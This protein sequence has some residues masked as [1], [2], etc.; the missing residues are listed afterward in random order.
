MQ[1]KDLKRRKLPD[2]P[3]VY[4][5]VG[6]KSK[7]LYIGKA[8]SLRD[9]VKSYFNKDLLGARGPAIVKMVAEAK[10]VDYTKTDSVLEALILEAH[11][12]KQFKPLYN[13]RS[14][15]DKS[16][17]Y[18][19]VT[20]EE[21]PRI[22]VVRGKDLPSRFPPRTRKYVFGPF[23][24]GLEFKEAMRLVRKLFPYYDTPVPVEEMTS[25]VQRGRLTFNRELG[26]YPS[27]GIS[28]SEYARTI[29][30]LVLF[31]EGK[32]SILLKQLTR[33]MKQYAKQ[34]VFEKAQQAK[35][36][37]FGLTHIQDISLLKREVRELGVGSTARGGFRIEAYDIAHLGGRDRVGV[38][39]VVEDDA[40]KKS[41][42]R[43]FRIKAAGEG[44]T[45]ALEEI[46][47]RR[48]AHSE[49]PLP[50]LIVMDG[51][52]AQLAFAKAILVRYGYRIPVVS[53]VKDNRHRPREILGDKRA[54]Q[55]HERS[56]LLAN[57]EAHRFAISFHRRL[58]RTRGA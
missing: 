21:F 47:E 9:R 32:K 48:L 25:K 26:L 18:V 28:K 46:L 6:T 50:Q 15:D 36:T 49:W 17:N 41:D 20:R 14:R 5:F 40:A 44:D 38:M 56:I 53:V 3:G 54:R 24:S 35:R 37:I 31:F 7:I 11:F 4:F 43:K 42:Y 19:V 29:R 1:V 55:T 8:T 27:R 51:G 22:M 45:K 52:K 57:R 33:E 13:I 10:T 58:R 30:H 16:F 23:P 2:A 12:I 34:E 39:T